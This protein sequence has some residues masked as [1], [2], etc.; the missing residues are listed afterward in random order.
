MTDLSCPA[1]GSEFDLATA[2]ASEE[3]R[4]ALA[5][6]VAVSVPMGARVLQYV[7]LHTPAK[8]RLTSA[9][10]IKLILQLLPD[11]ERQAVAHKGRDWSVPLTVWAAAIDQLLAQRDAGRLELP[12]K[13]H[14]YLYA[15]LA[16][17]ADKVGEQAEQQRDQ[18][19]RH[20]VR[21]NAAAPMDLAQ[22]ANAQDPALVAL[23]ER[24]R[25]AA[26][27]PEHLRLRMAA[28]SGR[29]GT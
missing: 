18:D 9:K 4:Q 25:K 24:D 22:L 28:I 21:P 16:G 29:K 10:K 20:A 8:Q 15:V 6:L 7:A 2:F 1:C 17:M 27:I 12:L 11:L 5:R 26:P 23:Q 13:G 19:L 14:G 3:D